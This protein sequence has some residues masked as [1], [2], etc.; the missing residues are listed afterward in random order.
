MMQPVSRRYLELRNSS[1]DAKTSTAKP[2]DATHLATAERI[3]SAQ[4]ITEMKE[5]FAIVIVPSTRLQSK[6]YR[7]VSGESI[8]R[9]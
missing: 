4:S 3:D 1:A 5:I 9:W 2:A 6:I 7:C 8:G